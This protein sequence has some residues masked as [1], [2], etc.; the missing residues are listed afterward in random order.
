MQRRRFLAAVGTTVAVGSAGCVSDSGG[1]G[2]GGGDAGS[3]RATLE[4]LA[5]AGSPG[6]ELPVLPA[7]PALLDFWA[8]WCAPCKP[9]MRELRA[10]RE[11][12]P[13]VHMLS[14]TNESDTAAVRDFWTAYEGTWAVAQD[15]ELRTNERFG[16]TRMPTLLVFDADGTEVWRHVGLAAADTVEA[17]LREAGAGGA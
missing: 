10:V 13:A 17:K 4:T 11:A 15:T 9:Q 1:A 6:G 8:T 2:A 16:V 5:V 14:I 3:D 7:E 12:L